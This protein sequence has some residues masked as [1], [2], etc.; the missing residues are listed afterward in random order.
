ML[1]SALDHD[2]L[3]PLITHTLRHLLLSQRTNSAS[4]KTVIVRARFRLAGF[5]LSLFGGSTL[6]FRG[7]WLL[8]SSLKGLGCLSGITL[9]SKEKKAY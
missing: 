8:L 7:S 1:L 3:Q 9:N 4:T 2:L 5:P 6:G